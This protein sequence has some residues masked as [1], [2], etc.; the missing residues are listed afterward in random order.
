MLFIECLSTNAAKLFINKSID[1][2]CWM[3]VNGIRDEFNDAIPDALPFDEMNES[4][5]ACVFVPIFD[6]V[7]WSICWFNHFEA[8]EL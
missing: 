8:V 5:C 6:N 4:I 1:M 3:F 7:V 2:S